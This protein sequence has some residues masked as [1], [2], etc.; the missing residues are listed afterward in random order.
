MVG[1]P[2]TYTHDFFHAFGRM[3]RTRR[4]SSRGAG[5]QDRA[6]DRADPPR[7]RARSRGDGARARTDPAG[8]DG[9]EAAA[10]WEGY[11]HG[12]GTGYRGQVE[13]ARGFTLVWAGPGIRTF[14][15]TGSRPVVEGQPTLFEIWVCCDGY[16][17]DHTKNLCVGRLEPRYAEL[18]EALHAVYD[19]AV[20]YLRDGAEL[21]GLDRHGARGNRRRRLSRPAVAPDLPRRRH[22][23]ARAAVRPPGGRRRHARGNGAGD[24]AGDLLARAAAACASRTTSSS[25]PRAARSCPRSR[26][27]S[28]RREPVQVAREQRRLADVLRAGE[29][30]DPALEPDCEPALRRH[31]V[32]ERLQV[33]LVGLG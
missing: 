21:A 6:G 18:L 32:P 25:R 24:R 28:S 16:W 5:D 12:V 14:T 10:I 31:A 9:G 33:A 22:A 27:A 23:R 17:A 29:P 4:R 15:A 26:T 1:E 7:E 20:S 2:T 8:D 30:G 11:V 19:G 13:L 3:S